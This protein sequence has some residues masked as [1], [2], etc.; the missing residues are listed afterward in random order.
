MD[1]LW[2]KL[3]CQASAATQRLSSFR[4]LQLKVLLGTSTAFAVWYQVPHTHGVLLCK[5]VWMWGAEMGVNDRGVA[6]GNEAVF[7]RTAPA[8]APALLGAQRALFLACLPPLCTTHALLI[9]CTAAGGTR[10]ASSP[11]SLGCSE[12]LGHHS[13][14]FTALHCMLQTQAWTSCASPSSDVTVLGMA[15]MCLLCYWYVDGSVSR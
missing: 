5:P 12:R 15:S 3:W 7:A 6:V 4:Y 13:P 1:N 10:Y 14:A 11:L 2:T 9:V 8:K